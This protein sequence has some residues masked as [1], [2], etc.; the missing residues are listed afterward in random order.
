MTSNDTFKT[1][2]Y[3]DDNFSIALAEKPQIKKQ[4]KETKT[5][6]EAFKGTVVNRTL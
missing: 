1:L 6:T 4:F 2:F 5:K 3:S